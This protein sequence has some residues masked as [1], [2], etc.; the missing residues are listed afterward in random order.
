MGTTKQYHIQGKKG[1]QFRNQLRGVNLEQVLIVAIDA[2]K[3]HQ[4]SLICNYFGDVIEKPFFFSVNQDGI[5]FLCSKINKAMKEHNAQRIFLGVEATGHYYEDIV[6]QLG[7]RGFGVQIFNA[8]TTFEERAS[9]LNWC[10]TDD[11]DLVAIAHAIMNNK[12]TEFTLAEGKQRQLLTF[13]RARRREVKKRAAL[14]IEIR[15]LMDHIWREYQGYAVE[16]NKKRKKVK[17]FSDF[18]GKSSLFFMKSYPHPSYILQLGE[19]GLRRLSKEYNLKL[20]QG[21]I[22]KLLYSANQALSRSLEELRP[23]LLILKMRLNDLEKLSKNIEALEMEIEPLLL[24][25]DGK[26]LLTVPGI[27]LVSAA[28]LYSEIGDVFQYENPGQIIKRA[29]TNPIMKQSGGGGGYFGRISK[30]GNPHLRYIIYNVGRC[31]S[32]HNKDLLPF[33]DR[34]K[35]RGKHPRKVFIALG[36]KFIKIDFAMLRDKKPFV[37]KQPE[38]N[39]LNEINKKL[40]YTCLFASIKPN[41]LAV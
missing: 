18:W 1:S 41:K 11:I 34:L 29:G 24:E 21:T 38:F 30:Q 15:V 25:T 3:L 12:G 28:E 35:E 36:N 6:R 20:R 33:V 4:K 40:S 31:L 7:E 19:S 37:S 14:Q 10:K 27:G 23:E 39:I 17:I 9:A 2:A 26:L 13:T 8:Y 22:Q 5:S 16:E 32:M